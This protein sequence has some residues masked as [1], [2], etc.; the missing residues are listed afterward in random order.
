MIGLRNNDCRS[1]AAA[2]CAAGTRQLA[3]CKAH[4]LAACGYV[5]IVIASLQ[6][7]TAQEPPTRK[8]IRSAVDA[9]LKW[10]ADR[11][12]K[13]GS[14]AGSWGNPKYQTASSSFAGLAFLANGYEPGKGEYGKVIDRS[15]QFVRG[16]MTPDGYLGTQAQSMYVHA[17]CTIFGLSYLGLSKNPEK[18]KEL[19]EWCH[20]AIKLIVEAQTI[21]KRSAEQGGWRYSPFSRES[22]LSVTSWQLLTLHAARQCGYEIGEEVFDSAMK[23][24]NR[25]FVET[26]DEGE[27]GFLYRIGTSKDPEPAV[28]GVAV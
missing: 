15:M 25:S 13:D 9:G 1:F 10:L 3:G 6:I 20:K 19:A 24:L 23:Y 5:L 18:E 14:D 26:K 27:G 4:S 28:T 7:V 8:Q 16:S 2:T 12:I 22:D 11:Q 17:V 21:R